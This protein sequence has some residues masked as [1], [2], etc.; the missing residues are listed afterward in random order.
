MQRRFIALGLAA[1]A[2]AGTV[3]SGCSLFQAAKRPAEEITI[4]RTPERV[5]RGSYLANHV[6]ACFGCHSPLDAN[7]HMPLPNMTGAGGRGF[8]RD[9]GLPGNIFSTNL[10]P[11][12]ETGLG[13]WTDGEI[14]RAM[15][16]GVS[17]DG[18]ALFPIMPYPNYR[19]MSDADAQAIVAYLRTLAPVKNAITPRQLDF[20]VSMI[21]NVIPKPV[22][23]PVAP[24]P[25]AKENAV[26]RGAYVAKMASC[27]ECHTPQTPQGPDKSK[28]FA[29]GYPFVVDGHTFWMPNL[30][31]DKETGLG[32]F[33]DRQVEDAIRYGQCPNGGMLSPVMPWPI[34]NGMNQEDMGALIAFLRTLPPIKSPPEPPGLH[35]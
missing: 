34:Y 13:T 25:T 26:G 10:T 5:A 20:P 21:V 4:Q 29:G 24:P 22:E 28:L 12:P 1:I 19:G 33:T 30:T 32:G 16:E 3:I 31:S 27:I 35:K 11:D 9:E 6:M 8:T 17:K 7:T 15:R 14:L 2:A 18:H 23:G